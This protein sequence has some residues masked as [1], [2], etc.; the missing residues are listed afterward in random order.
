MF[1]FRLAP[2]LNFRRRQE[3]NKQRDLAL[4]TREFVKVNGELEEFRDQ[5]EKAAVKL[6]DLGR[7][8][9]DVNVLKIY[10]DFIK[11]RDYDIENKKVEAKSAREVV[12]QRQEELL[13]YVKRRRSLQTYRERLEQRYKKEETRK[14]RIFMDEVAGQNWFK[15]RQW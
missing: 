4:A 7:R 12:T 2:L 14:E 11:G 10:E 8:N 15:E 3:E 5:K 1:L 6:N 13:E 9:E